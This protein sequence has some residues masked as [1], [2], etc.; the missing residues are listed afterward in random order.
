MTEFESCTGMGMTGTPRILGES[1]GKRSLQDS[2][3]DGDGRVL[4]VDPAG[5]KQ[6]L[7]DSHGDGKIVQDSY[8]NDTLYC[9]VTTFAPLA[10]NR[11]SAINFFQ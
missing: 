10:L 9:S 5:W 2:S 3:S 1:L 11:E 4:P 8:R 6:M 7:Q